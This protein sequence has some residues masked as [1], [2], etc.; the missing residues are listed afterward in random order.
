[1]SEAAREVNRSRIRVKAM[2]IA[3][4]PEGTAHAVSVSGPSLENPEG[5]HRLIG[6]S[7]ELGETHRECII[8]EVDEELGARIDDLR[9]LGVVE[10]IFRYEGEL[11]HE[12]VF[13]WTGLLD[14]PPALE[15]AT[16]TEIDGSVLPVVW[17]RFGGG[18]DVVPLY[19]ARAEDLFTA[20]APGR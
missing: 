17:R 12:I 14:P 7:V 8:R 2:L 3:P 5:F 18:E 19:P 6:G 1:M 13:V 16:M 10:N 9:F 11:G 20:E 4:N 15:G